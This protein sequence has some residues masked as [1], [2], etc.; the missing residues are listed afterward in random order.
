MHMAEQDVPC[1]GCGYNL[2][3]CQK[4][5]CPECGVALV[6][7]VNHTGGDH[8]IRALRLLFLALIVW[9][10]AG[11]LPGAVMETI[12][13]W[14]MV[15]RAGGALNTS[16]FLWYVVSEIIIALIALVL[17]ILGLRATYQMTRAR[18]ARQYA[19]SILILQASATVYHIILA[20]V[21]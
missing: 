9:S 12:S 15:G 8:Y 16:W 17:S 5:A 3:G 14:E 18:D 2:R 7:S 20:I 21:W 10:G 4:A 19:L 11:Q 13:A 6:L 1:P